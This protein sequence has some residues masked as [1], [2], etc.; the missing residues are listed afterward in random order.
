Y[1][2]SRKEIE[3]CR[4]NRSNPLHEYVLGDFIME[5]TEERFDLVFAHAVIDHVYDVD[6]FVRAVV[7]ATNRWVY[8]TAYRGWFPE[9]EQHR[10]H[11]SDQETCFYND[12]SPAQIRR[13]LVGL[14]CRDVRVAR[15]R[16]PIQPGLWETVIVAERDPRP[17]SV[18][19]A[20]DR[21]SE[22]H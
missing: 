7:E 16:T 14:G 17:R 15:S 22:E 5:G 19:K 13:L 6:A 20:D 9:L 10:Y 21:R 8:L 4:A 11:W 18:R 12:L 1:D 3:W 2:I